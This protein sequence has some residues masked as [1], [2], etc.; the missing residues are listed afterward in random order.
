MTTSYPTS[1][2]PVAIMQ[3]YL[4]ATW[5]GIPADKDMPPGMAV[6]LEMIEGQAVIT[7]AVLKGDRGEKGDP[8]RIVD[9]Q[10]PPKA[11]AAEL[12]TNLTA[13]DENKGWWVGDPIPDRV[14]V[15]TGTTYEVVRPGPPGPPGP[16]PQITPTVEVIPM[17]E[18][19]PD[20]V[21]EVIVTNDGA[22]PQW[23][24]RLLA[25]QG[26]VGPS[27]N[28]TGAPDYDGQ[29]RPKEP[30][31]VLTVL[32]NGK[33]GASD[34]AAK[35]PRFYSIPE[36]M[37][38]PF[39]GPAQRHT[40]LQYTIEAQD[41]DWVPYVSGHFRAYGI[42]IDADPLI[43]GSEVRL[44]DPL[45]GTLIARG[46]GNNSTWTTVLPHFSSTGNTT[47]AV[48]PDNGHAMVPAGQPAQ[49]SVNLYND[50]LLGVYLFNPAGAQLDVLV[51]PQG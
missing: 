11:T 35:H 33:F 30:G 19:T 2:D 9:L 26:P 45:S 46:F 8:G 14:Y 44:G 3:S 32:P 49:I 50:G 43:I 37:F 18:R 29:G 23:H 48:A 17:E 22:F 7:S 25:P 28:I 40:I 47:A 27:T 6:T 4:A 13:A 31:Q 38:S 24:M 20:S 21:S 34:F 10:W 51:I 36:G 16:R 15:W 39:S 12:P 5:I 41:Y 42:E 1:N